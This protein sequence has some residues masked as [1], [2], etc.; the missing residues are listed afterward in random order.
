MTDEPVERQLR[1]GNGPVLPTFVVETFTLQQQR[2]AV[3]LEPAF[4]H[5]TFREDEGRLLATGIFEVLNHPVIFALSRSASV[6]MDHRSVPDRRL[7][8][9][10]AGP[11][12]AVRRPLSDGFI[13][14]R[15]ALLELCCVAG[16]QRRGEQWR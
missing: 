1:G 15:Q 13:G 5:L 3:E 14:D 11:V 9:C 4:E 16:A 2:G 8:A 7:R 12:S 6:S 10:A